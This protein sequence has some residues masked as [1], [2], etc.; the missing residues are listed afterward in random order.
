VEPKGKVDINSDS[1]R[2]YL[3]IAKHICDVVEKVR[4]RRPVLSSSFASIGVDSLGAVMFVKYLSES[5]GII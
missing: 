2:E 5:L 4:G 3:S 1:H